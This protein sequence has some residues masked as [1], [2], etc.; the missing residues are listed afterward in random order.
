MAF[1]S[2]RTDCKTASP[3]VHLLPHKWINVQEVL[4]DAR[5]TSYKDMLAVLALHIVL[6]RPVF[7]LNDCVMIPL[8]PSPSL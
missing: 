4:P 3:A 2:S 6:V 7:Q 8:P 1:I 5:S